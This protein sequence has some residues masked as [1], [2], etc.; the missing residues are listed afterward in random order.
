MLTLAYQV[1]N[2]LEKNGG[3]ELE[4][5]DYHNF[6]IADIPYEWYEKTMQAIGATTKDFTLQIGK[7]LPI[8]QGEDHY[9]KMGHQLVVVMGSECGFSDVVAGSTMKIGTDVYEAIAGQPYYFPTNVPHNFRGEFYFINLQNPPLI[10]K[11]GND[12][13]YELSIDNSLTKI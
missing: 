7:C 11:D 6:P 8:Y 5:K 9:H 2:Y 10:D 1:M 13:Y 4:W 3:G 12:D